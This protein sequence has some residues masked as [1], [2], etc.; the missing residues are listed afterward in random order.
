[1]KKL[2]TFILLLLLL[3]VPVPSQGRVGMQFTEEK[4]L[5][6]ETIS[7]V[8]MYLLKVKTCY[9]DKCTKWYAVDKYFNT[10]EDAVRFLFTLDVYDNKTLDD[11]YPL[12]IP[13]NNE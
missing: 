7:L 13:E 9:L 3:S 10:Y 1:M 12:L 11:F 8:D 6:F 4:I 2:L 5:V